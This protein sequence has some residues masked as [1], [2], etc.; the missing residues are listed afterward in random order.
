[1]MVIGLRGHAARLKGNAGILEPIVGGGQ[2]DDR[3]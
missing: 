3:L 2:I 1:M